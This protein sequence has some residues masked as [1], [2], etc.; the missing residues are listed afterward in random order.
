MEDFITKWFVNPHK[1]FF[2]KI[3]GISL[4][5][6]VVAFSFLEKYV[7]DKIWIKSTAY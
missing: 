1:V 2:N 3:N 7:Y 5:V 6:K 4:I